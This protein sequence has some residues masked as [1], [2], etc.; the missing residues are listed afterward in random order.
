MEPA[1]CGLLF[2]EDSADAQELKESGPVAEAKPLVTDLVS[3]FLSR[4]L[5]DRVVTLNCPLQV[6]VAMPV[7]HAGELGESV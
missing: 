2:Q 4:S 5:P 1:G 6:L 7:P 3:H